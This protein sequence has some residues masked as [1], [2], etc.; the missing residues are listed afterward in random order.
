M[1][2]TRPA[3]WWADSVAASFPAPCSPR[4][5]RPL[6]ISTATTPRTGQD[7]SWSIRVRTGSA[8]FLLPVPFSHSQ[9][10]S[11]QPSTYGKR[12]HKEGWGVGGRPLDAGSPLVACFSGPMRISNP[13]WRAFSRVK[14]QQH[15]WRLPSVQFRPPTVFPERSHPASGI[16][17]RPAGHFPSALIGLLS[18][19]GSSPVCQANYPQQS[20]SYH[21]M[22]DSGSN[23]GAPTEPSQ[24]DEPI[25]SHWGFP[26]YAHWG[27]ALLRWSPVIGPTPP[28]TLS[29]EQAHP[30]PSPL[31][32]AITCG[33]VDCTQSGPLFTVALGSPTSP[34]DV[35][36]VGL[37]EPFVLTSFPRFFHCFS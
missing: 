16:P 4:P 37:T 32:G 33:C 21:M 14:A 34:S 8:C 3:A 23:P 2:P 29:L 6:C 36:L 20:A 18:P 15:R 12:K 25:N 1:A 24:W 27:S 22:E 35:S 13:L 17:E 11:S 28:G 9:P 26:N 10:P 19:S 7:S 5:T 31:W 30:L